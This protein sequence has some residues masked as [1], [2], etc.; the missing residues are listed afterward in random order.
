MVVAVSFCCASSSVVVAPTAALP[1]PLKAVDIHIPLGNTGRT[2]TL[3]ELATMKI[4]DVERVTGKKMG[5]LQRV[6]VKLAQRKLRHSINADGTISNKR[7]A[8]L[9]SR[10]FDGEEGFHLGGFALGLC[11]F[12]IG[13]LIAYLINDP[14]Q[15][16]R[17]KWAW[18]GAGVL[19]AIVL[20][21]HL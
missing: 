12:L 6:E 5:L 9:T 3:Q 14:K 2:V 16:N 8:M 4:A 1:A 18:I 20:V 19:L 10:E 13:V 21:T 7:L 17:V 11:L 15:R